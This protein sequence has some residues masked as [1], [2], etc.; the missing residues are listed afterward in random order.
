MPPRAPECLASQGDFTLHCRWAADVGG[1]YTCLNFLVCLRK[2][3]L[4]ALCTKAP[5]PVVYPRTHAPSLNPWSWKN[6]SYSLPHPPSFPSKYGAGPQDALAHK[7]S[8][9]VC[10][11]TDSRKV[12]QLCVGGHGKDRAEQIKAREGRP[13]KLLNRG[14]FQSSRAEP[15]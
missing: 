14:P 11:L 12:G 7:A 2:L 6:L 4:Q 3:F 13:G 10:H 1:W 15:L 5:Q 9:R 8:T